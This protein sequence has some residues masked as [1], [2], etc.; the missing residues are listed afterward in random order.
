MHERIC[1]CVYVFVCVC[2]CVD[3]LCV[4]VCTCVCGCVCTCVCVCE[5]ERERFCSYG[6]DAASCAANPNLAVPRSSVPTRRPERLTRLGA[7]GSPLRL[8]ACFARAV[9]ACCASCCAHVLCL[10]P[11]AKRG[12]DDRPAL[13]ANLAIGPLRPAGLNA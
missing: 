4:C 5:R 3:V 8:P 10:V 13:G 7:S 12:H 6:Q 1:V 11:M 2:V 9:L